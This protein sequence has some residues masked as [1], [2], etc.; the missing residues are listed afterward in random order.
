MNND[1][2]SRRGSICSERAG[3]VI[4]FHGGGKEKYAVISIGN[5][6]VKISY[7]GDGE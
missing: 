2:R 4:G 5:C 3:S 6:K 7:T 1:L